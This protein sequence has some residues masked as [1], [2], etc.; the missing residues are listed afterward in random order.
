MSVPSIRVGDLPDF[1]AGDPQWR[2]TGVDGWYDGAVPRAEMFPNGAGPGATPVGPWDDAEA[3]YL[4]RGAIIADDRATLHQRRR[5]LLEALPSD[6]T[7]SFTV[8]DDDDVDLQAF[9]RRYDKPTIELVTGNLLTFQIPLVAFDPLKYAA[10]S[11][12]GSMGVFTGDTWFRSDFL[13][14]APTPD[15]GYRVYT[16]DSGTTYYRTYTQETSVGVF[17]PA[18]VLTSE[19]DATSRKLT[20]AVTGPLTQGDWH[21]VNEATGDELWADLSLSAGQTIVF[22]CYT[23]RA[24]IDGAPVDSLVF[25]DFLTLEPGDNTYRLVSGQQS[26]G[27]ASITTALPAYK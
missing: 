3:Y 10:E 24:T 14:T 8:L 19:G 17:Q 25:G 13:D 21:L 7:V 27:F 16:L 12:D 26:S 22:D 1:S 4:F 6:E 23:Q 5:A 9:V 20:I 2:C 15:E 18:A 11:L